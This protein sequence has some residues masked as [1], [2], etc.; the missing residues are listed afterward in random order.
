[1]AADWDSGG[2]GGGGD[3]VKISETHTSDAGLDAYD[4]DPD[5]ENYAAG[6]DP[7]TAYQNQ[8]RPDSPNGLGRYTS[9]DAYQENEHAEYETELG[10]ENAETQQA[11]H[12]SQTFD[13][14]GD[15]DP[16]AANYA[17]LDGIGTSS[18]DAKDGPDKDERAPD[19]STAADASQPDQDQPAERNVEE[20]QP[21]EQQRISAL[22]AENADARQQLAYANPKI[23]ELEA[24]NDD[25]AARLDRIEQFLAD[26]HQNQADAGAQEHGGDKPAASADHQTAQDVAISEHKTTPESRDVRDAEGPRWR[27]MSSAENVGLASTALSAADTVAQFTMHATPEGVV[28]LGAMV[29]GVASVG[30]AKLEKKR[31][32]NKKT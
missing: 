6:N 25:Q 20:T 18:P 17:D 22:E 15:A 21:P 30:L 3:T 31:K 11:S 27:R 8:G 12:T 2:Y 29:L 5:A 19:R 9:Q 24:K 13:M 7:E 4:V 14:W 16:D 1:M 10:D 23:A 28:G 32:E 26:S